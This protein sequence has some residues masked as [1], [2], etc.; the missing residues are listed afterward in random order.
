MTKFSCTY[1]AEFCRRVN[2]L[3]SMLGSPSSRDRMYLLRNNVQ[4]L[5]K[6]HR[7]RYASDLEF[8]T[9]ESASITVVS[10]MVTFKTCSLGTLSLRAKITLSWRDLLNGKRSF[11]KTDIPALPLLGMAHIA[12]TG[13]YG[14]N[15]LF[16]TQENVVKR[17]T[18][19]IVKGNN[20]DQRRK[21]CMLM[22]LA[23]EVGCILQ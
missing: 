2:H 1:S 12:S 21:K 14:E 3:P 16:G 18:Y 6:Y 8:H 15:P 17:R 10:L 23:M 13:L 4:K 20:G 19:S 9:P 7:M 11:E 5:K 22:S